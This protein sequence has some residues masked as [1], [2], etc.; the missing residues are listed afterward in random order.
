MNTNDG[1]RILDDQNPQGWMFNEGAVA[2]ATVDGSQYV[3]TE[4]NMVNLDKTLA[5]RIALDYIDDGIIE[6]EKRGE[7]RRI[8]SGLS[9]RDFPEKL[10]DDKWWLFQV[11]KMG[12]S[13]VTRGTVQI[14]YDT[15]SSRAWFAD[16]KV[17]GCTD[18]NNLSDA[19][20]RYL[21][22]KFDPLQA[23]IHQ[24]QDLRA[25]KPTS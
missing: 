20:R 8:A 17:F 4:T 14:A 19:L 16:G 15:V 23:D 2:T 10:C 6:S 13:V 18:C 1:R 22:G 12:E 11:E 25:G 21:S 5:Y 9:Y 3:I 24:I 7:A